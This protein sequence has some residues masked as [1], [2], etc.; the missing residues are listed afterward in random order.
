M[1]P[2][3]IRL[4]IL[5]DSEIIVHGVAAMLAPYADRVVVIDTETGDEEVPVASDIVLVD[6]FARVQEPTL[7]AKEMLDQYNSQRLVIYTWN[8]AQTAQEEALAGGA[9]GYLSKQ[10]TGLQLVETLEQIHRGETV[11]DLTEDDPDD[12]DSE[13]TWPGAEHGITERESEILVLI[14]GGLSNQE[15]AD[16]LYLSINTIKTYIR[17]AYRRIGAQSRSQAMLWGIDHG[18][19]IHENPT[20]ETG[21]L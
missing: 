7:D 6:T 4:V 11:V 14:V 13:R 3:P 15:V 18:F 1:R 8:L 12:N 19:R 16:Y 9:C 20:R 21:G 2:S 10:L 17:S 5:N